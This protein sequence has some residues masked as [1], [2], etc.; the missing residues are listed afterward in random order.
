[1]PTWILW[2]AVAAG[3]AYT[4]SGVVLAVGGAV[5]GA[6]AWRVRERRR[7]RAVEAERDE[8]LVDVV[9][10]ITA[11]VRAGQSVPQALVVRRGRD[12]SAAA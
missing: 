6:V 2:S 12:S 10:S 4:V 7:A 9:T 1:M 3:V 5:A 8:Q 11:A